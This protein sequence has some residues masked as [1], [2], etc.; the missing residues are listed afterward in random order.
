MGK[1]ADEIKEK[2]QKV[3][4]YMYPSDPMLVNYSEAVKILTDLSEQGYGCASYILGNLYCFGI[5]VE[6]NTD[7]GRELLRLGEEQGYNREAYGLMEAE[8][9]GAG[10]WEAG[11]FPKLIDA[12]A[13][14]GYIAKSMLYMFGYG[15]ISNP[16]RKSDL[17]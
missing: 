12:M 3:F 14:D 7:K 13:K 9:K 1:T 16:N 15:P 5:G 8:I 4:S 11:D 17:V 10:V 2:F 6:K